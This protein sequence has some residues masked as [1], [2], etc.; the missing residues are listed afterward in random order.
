M[1]KGVRWIV[2]AGR[3]TPDRAPEIVRQ[4]IA[5]NVYHLLDNLLLIRPSFRERLRCEDIQGGEHLDRA[6]AAGK[7]VILE[8]GH[9]YANRMAERYFAS[10]GYPVLC[11]RNQ[12]PENSGS[13]RLGRCILQPRLLEFRRRASAQVVYIQDPEC[14]L[15][16]L[17]RLR[18]GGVVNIQVDGIVG[19]RAVAGTL[20]GRPWR[21][22]AGIFDLVRRSGCAVVPMLCVGRIAGFRISFD[23]ALDLAM[24]D[25]RD[26][27]LA[28]NL[29]VIVRALEE[30]IAGHPEEWRLWTHF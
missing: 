25:S 5:N 28:S 24:A 19:T 21:F 14:S 17:R 1:E 8:T 26:E 10:T 16:I 27:W 4:S 29:P 3:A 18:S 6:L 11:V 30:Q 9:F 20:L 23:P 15:K 22:P 12:R 7:G 2:S 13:G